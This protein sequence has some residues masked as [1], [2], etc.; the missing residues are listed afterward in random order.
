MW[1]PQVAD[2]EEQFAALEA[3]KALKGNC[4]VPAKYP[5]NP[6]LATWVST[7]RQKKKNRKL[8]AERIARLEKLDFVWELLATPA[9][10]EEQ[11][12]ALK[13]YKALKGNCNVPQDYPENPSLGKW[14]SKQRRTK[15]TGT[16]SGERIARLEALGFVW[17]LR[18]GWPSTVRGAL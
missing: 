15:K 13:A 4:N 10:W 5:E 16:L 17:E 1:D 9:T 11:F 6:S 8:S 18:S 12:A 14:V 3:Y 7:Q 2:W